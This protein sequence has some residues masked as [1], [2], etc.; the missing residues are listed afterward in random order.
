MYLC[1]C[2]D[3]TK[4][5]FICYLILFFSSLFWTA[6][7]MCRCVQRGKRKRETAGRTLLWQPAAA[8][9]VLPL[10]SCPRPKTFLAFPVA[11]GL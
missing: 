2:A 5:Q 8:C 11:S 7:D 3:K 1:F 9:Q 10:P 6:A 4:L